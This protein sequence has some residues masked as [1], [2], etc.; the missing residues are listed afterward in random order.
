MFQGTGDGNGDEGIVFAMVMICASTVKVASLY[1][2]VEDR[3]GRLDHV[4]KADAMQLG[5]DDALTDA[6]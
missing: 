2:S 1:F 5:S 6:R 3:G 4:L